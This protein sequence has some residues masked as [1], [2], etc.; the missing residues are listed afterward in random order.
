MPGTCQILSLILPATLKNEY[1]FFV[2]Y[3]KGTW[4]SDVPLNHMP[5]RQFTEQK[6]WKMNLLL[7]V[8]PLACF[9]AAF[10]RWS[11]FPD[12][13]TEACELPKIMQLTQQCNSQLLRTVHCGRG[14]GLRVWHALM[15]F[16]YITACFVSTGIYHQVYLPSELSTHQLSFKE[17]DGGLIYSLAFNGGKIMFAKET[18]NENLWGEAVIATSSSECNSV[19]S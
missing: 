1:Q 15:Y 4:S 9:S 19:Y 10:S 8:K 13:E 5:R 2:L 12:E 11:V 7:S 3:R 16:T 17:T 14:S 6:T 18:P